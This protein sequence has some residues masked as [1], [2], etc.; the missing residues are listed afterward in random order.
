MKKQFPYRIVVGWS[1]DD[2]AFV[3]R[4]P[5][6]QHCAAH[7]NTPDAAVR[8]VVTAAEGVLEVM[9]EDGQKLPRPDGLD[10]AA[11]AS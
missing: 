2:D 11:A 1:E 3:A 7:G 6:L 10:V 4:V 5:A 8:E 9:R